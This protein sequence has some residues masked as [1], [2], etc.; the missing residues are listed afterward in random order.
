MAAPSAGDELS[1]EVGFLFGQLD[2][3][4]RQGQEALSAARA[5]VAELEAG[6]RDQRR[7]LLDEA[8]AEAERR[9]ASLLADRRV[10][11][12]QRAAAML[13]DA[14]RDA[15]LMLA[16]GREHTPA[17]VGKIVERLL[18]GPE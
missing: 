14:E 8:H 1:R 7:W 16:R 17:L 10:A 2:R 3:L 6:A 11:C 12:E 15:E 4:D 5:L 9:A 13:A 18:A